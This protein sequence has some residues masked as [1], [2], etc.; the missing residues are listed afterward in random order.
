[1]NNYQEALNR[2]VENSCP[3]KTNCK[4]CE[5]SKS[6]NCQM[7]NEVD[8]LQELIDSKI[9]MNQLIKKV[10]LIKHMLGIDN[11]IFKKNQVKHKCYR[12][13]FCGYDEICEE[14]VKEMLV[15]KREDKNDKTY[16][17][18]TKKGL[19]FIGNLLDMVITYE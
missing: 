11:T 17:Y 15:Q 8:K 19:E 1:M 12:N 16:Y 7:K 13:Y 14:L 5:I 9:S 3:K 18:V 6:F 2:I 4:E 10:Y